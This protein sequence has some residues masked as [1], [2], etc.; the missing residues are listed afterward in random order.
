MFTC[1]IR[2]DVSEEIREGKGSEE[3]IWREFN[4]AADLARLEP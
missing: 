3:R 1:K 2:R 4:K